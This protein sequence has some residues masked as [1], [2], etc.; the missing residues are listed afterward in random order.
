ML[1]NQPLCVGISL[2]FKIVY[3]FFYSFLNCFI[4]KNEKYFNHFI[5]SH[6]LRKME[7]TVDTNNNEEYNMNYHSK[8]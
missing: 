1:P 3:R 2:L 4:K 8:V 5:N 6:S 7:V